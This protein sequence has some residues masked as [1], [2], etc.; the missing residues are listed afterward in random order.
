MLVG[1]DKHGLA[2]CYRCSARKAMTVST[3]WL[4]P[5]A[6]LVL[7]KVPGARVP[8]AVCLVSGGGNRVH[9]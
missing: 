8:R 4:S 5:A 1:G 3:A 6:P 7:T 9:R 2:T